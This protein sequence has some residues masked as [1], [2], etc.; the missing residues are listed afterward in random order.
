MTMILGTWRMALEGTEKAWMLLQEGGSAEDAVETAVSEVEDNPLYRSVGYG[1]LPD[2]DGEVTLDA[3]F[4]EG[5]NL[6]YGA[7]FSLSGFRHPLSIARLLSRE[8]LNNCLAGEG[9]AAWARE[10]GFAEE[11]LRTPEAMKIYKEEKAALDPSVY[12]GHDTVGVLALDSRGHMA[13]GTSTSGLFLKTPGRVGDSPLIGNGFYVDDRIGGAAATGVGEEIM[14]GCLSYE[15]V[16]RMKDGATPQEACD[17]AL[18][19]LHRRVVEIRGSAYDLSV[20]AMDCKGRIGAAS[21]IANF[22]FVMPNEKGKVTPYVAVV[23]T[24]TTFAPASAEW[25]AAYMEER[26]R[27]KKESW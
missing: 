10:K 11:E 19:A 27:G 16:R 2:R 26:R 6:T 1:G 7:V 18:H 12:R 4:M 25:L 8:K 17:G 20:I 15:I 13:V 3:G 23:G 5:R 14:R 21:N 9:A 22:S 24:K